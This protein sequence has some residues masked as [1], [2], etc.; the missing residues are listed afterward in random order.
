MVQCSSVSRSNVAQL[1]QSNDL[2]VVKAQEKLAALKGEGVTPV[3]KVI[4]LLKQLSGQVKEDGDAEAKA[5]DKYSCFCKEQA[6]QKLY[7]IETS[8][9]KLEELDA[10]IKQL[11]TDIA[12]LGAEIQ[13]L[14]KEITDLETEIKTETTKREANHAAYL[15]KEKDTV[16]AIDAIQRATAALNE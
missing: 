14:Q 10:K 3:E 7:Q 13:A 4:E 8:E 6:D 12:D 15:V 16:D 1:P 5:Y 2:T 11:N 9:K